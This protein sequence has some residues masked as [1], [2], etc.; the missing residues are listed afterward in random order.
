M[1]QPNLGVP[2]FRVAYSGQCRD[3]VKQLLTRAAARGRWSGAARRGHGDPGQVGNADR[4]AV[5]DETTAAAAVDH[6]RQVGVIGVGT[7]DGQGIAHRQVDRGDVGGQ[8]Q[9]RRDRYDIAAAGRRG[10]AQVNCGDRGIEVGFGRDGVCD[11][12]RHVVPQI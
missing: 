12:A 6:R 4:A 5:D 1:S 7:L 11:G 8:R 10:A 2:P 9:V 3:S